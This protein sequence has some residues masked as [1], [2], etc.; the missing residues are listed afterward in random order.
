[1][2][3]KVRTSLR[4]VPLEVTNSDRRHLPSVPRRSRR[5]RCWRTVSDYWGTRSADDDDAVG[6]DLEPRRGPPPSSPA[7]AS[8][9]SLR[10]V[11]PRRF[12]L[13]TLQAVRRL[14]SDRRTPVSFRARA[15]PAR[16][17]PW[18]CRRAPAP[19]VRTRSTAAAALPRLLAIVSAVSSL[20]GVIFVPALRKL[21]RAEVSSPTPSPTCG[22]C[23]S[24]G[25]RRCGCCR[26]FRVLPIPRVRG[27]ERAGGTSVRARASRRRRR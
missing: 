22:A 16:P 13:C 10:A 14:S 20:V 21:A 15:P 7:L 25:H 8:S 1:V 6:A 17:L 11:A 9:P 23:A 18:H 12:G 3:A 19:A 27:G 26:P 4:L 5:L 24:C 2:L